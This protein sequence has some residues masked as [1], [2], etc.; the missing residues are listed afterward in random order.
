MTR[1]DGTVPNVTPGHT[2]FWTFF[3]LPSPVY[4]DEMEA[5]GLKGIRFSFRLRRDFT[6]RLHRHF[7]V[8]HDG[9]ENKLSGETTDFQGGSFD[10]SF[11]NSIVL[12]MGIGQPSMRVIGMNSEQGCVK[13][14]GYCNS[15]RLSQVLM[16]SA[17]GGKYMGRVRISRIWDDLSQ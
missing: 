16:C 2:M 12:S 4:D 10:H 7:N 8:E 14:L 6:K 11:K 17:L 9:C 13:E 5:V 3:L 15:Y 1:C